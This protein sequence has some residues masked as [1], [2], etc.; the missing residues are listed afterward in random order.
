MRR[1]TL[2][3][4]ALVAI[5]T[6][7]CDKIK[8]I[9]D[10]IKAKLPGAKKTPATAIHPAADTSKVGAATK[11][12]PGT[13]TK[14]QPGGPVAQRPP[15]PRLTSSEPVRDKPY[16]SQDTGTIDPGM[17]ERDVYSQWGP[18]MGVR[19]M[20]EY[21][22]IFFPNGCER[23]CGTADVV[24]L[25]NNRVIDAIVRWPGHHYSGQS[26]SP[27]SMPPGG[28]PHQGGDTTKAKHDSSP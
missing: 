15:P 21:T 10:S 11:G 28:R 26:T 22:Y 5:A 7:G 18:P 17:A 1:S 8:P 19:K 6:L 14:G 3:V 27:A 13:P 23:T 20:G 4:C 25:Q 9:V 16:A 24:T 12:Q 2:W